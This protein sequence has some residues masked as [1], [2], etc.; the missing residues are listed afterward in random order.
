MVLAW[1][2]KDELK[3]D[4]KE[5]KTIQAVVG[6]EGWWVL[7]CIKMWCGL[8]RPAGPHC[9][10]WP[11]P[12]IHCSLS[13][14]PHALSKGWGT[15]ITTTTVHTIIIVNCTDIPVILVRQKSCLVTLLDTWWRGG[16]CWLLS[17]SV[18]MGSGSDVMDPGPGRTPGTGRCQ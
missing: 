15:V 10:A 5:K 3:I 14:W 16:P 17:L 8:G 1:R 11:G 18:V 13:Q 6:V 4:I 2:N 9:L 7:R 12:G